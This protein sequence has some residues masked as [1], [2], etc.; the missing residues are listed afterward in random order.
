MLETR[1]ARAHF[2]PRL[3][4]ATW[5]PYK[6]SSGMAPA[7][8]AKDNGGWNPAHRAARNKHKDVLELLGA[9]GA[10]LDL[11]T[12][13]GF[14]VMDLLEGRDTDNLSSS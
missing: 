3:G 10:D 5:L 14:T 1:R 2:T 6:F 4:K 8:N 11:E 12:P 13:E 9:G 7:S